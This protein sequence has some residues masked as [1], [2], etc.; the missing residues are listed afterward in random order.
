MKFCVREE[1]MTLIENFIPKVI[2]FHE[3]VCKITEIMKI[4]WN[5]K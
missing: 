3:K 2:P 4:Y 1:F 5:I